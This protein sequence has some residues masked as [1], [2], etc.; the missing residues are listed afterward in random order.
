MC[1]DVIACDVVYVVHV[2]VCVWLGVDAMLVMF[3]AHIVRGVENE[4]LINFLVGFWCGG[5]FASEERG[6]GDFDL[7]TRG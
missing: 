5:S 4:Q 7:G 3:H 2:C 6:Q 1:C